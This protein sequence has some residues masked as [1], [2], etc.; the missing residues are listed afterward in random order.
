LLD[1]ANLE[2]LGIPTV[3]FVTEPFESAA[4]TH[5]EIHGLPDMPMIVVSQDYLVEESDDAVIARDAHIFD[6]VVEAITTWR[7]GATGATDRVEATA[8]SRTERS[9]ASS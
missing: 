2:R 7:A 9:P 1:H 8:A 6:L 4:H 5:A 3:T